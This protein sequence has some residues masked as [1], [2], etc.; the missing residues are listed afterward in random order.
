[1]SPTCPESGAWRPQLR[2]QHREC[3][4]GL[5]WRQRPPGRC[6]RD[7]GGFLLPPPGPG[8]WTL[9]TLTPRGLAAVVPA[10]V[11]QSKPLWTSS[12]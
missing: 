4:A 12:S 8:L 11:G 1:M 10:R 9:P 5:H 6:P 3:T 7:L 2:L